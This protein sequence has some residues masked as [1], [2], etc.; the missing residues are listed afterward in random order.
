[1]TDTIK[2]H[3]GTL[4]KY[5]GDC[6]MAFWGAPTH[7]DNHAVCC[8]RAAIEAQRAVHSLNMQRAE[9]NKSREAENVT[10]ISKGE[11][12]LPLLRQLSLGTGVNTGIVTVGLMGSDAHI[13]NYTVLGRE[14]NLASRLEGHSGRGRI[15]IGEA[16]YRAL[17]QHAPDLAGTCVEEFA[18]LRGFSSAQR[19]YEVPWKTTTLSPAL[20]PAASHPPEPIKL[21]GS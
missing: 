2:R 13:V 18:K 1:M 6:V 14:V 5:I 19:I 20:A 16:T 17:L 9:E 4:D 8:V 21:P 15:L 10:R 3:D 11:P 12:A 7:M